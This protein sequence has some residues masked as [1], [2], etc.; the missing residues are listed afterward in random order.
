MAAPPRTSTATRTGARRALPAAPLEARCDTL[1]GLGTVRQIH[2][3]LEWPSKPA[4]PDHLG[5]VL[6]GEGQEQ[7]PARDVW[8]ER[9]ERGWTEAV[10]AELAQTCQEILTMMSPAMAPSMVTPPAWSGR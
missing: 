9:A 6:P 8:A 7:A 5:A 4:L 2:D 3:W 10:R 1:A